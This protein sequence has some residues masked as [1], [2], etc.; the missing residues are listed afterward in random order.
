MPPRALN[1]ADVDPDPIRQFQTWLQDAIAADVHEPTVMT[2]ATATP[3]GQP[4]ARLVLLKGVDSRGFVFYTNYDSRKGQELAANPRAALVFYWQGLGRSVR[5]EG[6]VERVSAE[7]SD[8]YFA[9]RP[10]ASRLGA[11][12]S[13]QSQVIPSREPLDQGLA[14]ALAAYRDGGD[15]PRPAGWGG[16]RVTPTV[17]EFWQGRPNRLHDRLRYTLTD[18][19]AWRIDRLAP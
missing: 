17:I 10:L 1:K 14:E 11:I 5:V 12:I 7:E 6:T 4:S 9:S 16:F 8:T 3:D 15:P 13:P 18:D 19:G 2:L